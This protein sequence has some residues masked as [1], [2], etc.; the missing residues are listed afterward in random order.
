MA[1]QD[2]TTIFK[3]LGNPHRLKIFMDLLK[4][5]RQGDNVCCIAER[6][7]LAVSTVSHHLKELRQAGLIRC[8]RDGQSVI[9]SLDPDAVKKFQSF[10]K[11]LG[12]GR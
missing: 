4:A 1:A 6:A 9:C 7:C 5:R 3:A 2:M 8:H 10:V 11:S 12:G